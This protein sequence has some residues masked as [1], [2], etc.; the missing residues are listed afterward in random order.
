MTQ[1]RLTKFRHT[2]KGIQP[3]PFRSHVV[4]LGLLYH[5]ELLGEVVDTFYSDDGRL[6]VR[7]R[8]FNGEPWPIEPPIYLVDVLVRS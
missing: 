1:Q 3:E 4:Y 5:R 2:N 7:V 8:H 6:R